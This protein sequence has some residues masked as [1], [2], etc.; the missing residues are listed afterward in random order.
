MQS[1]FASK[2]YEANTG[3]SAQGIEVDE[4][5]IPFKTN[6]DSRYHCSYITA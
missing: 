1:D 3:P 2:L 4:L 6:H 5:G